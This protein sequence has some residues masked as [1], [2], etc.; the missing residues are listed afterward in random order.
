[1]GGTA[2]NRD[3]LIVGLA[4]PFAEANTKDPH[5][6]YAP[7]FRRF[8]DSYDLFP[9]RRIHQRHRGHALAGEWIGWWRTFAIVGSHGPMPAGLLALG[10][11]G[12]APAGRGLFAD[13]SED[14][15]VWGLSAAVADHGTDCDLDEVSVVKRTPG[16]GPAF[17]NARVLE[18]GAGAVEV[19]ERLTRKPLPPTREPEMH[20][21]AGP[22][23][24][25]GG[26]IYRDEWQE[27]VF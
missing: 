20:P 1:L 9:P 18:V 11:F 14:P 2:V 23:V 17:G 5:V 16:D 22:P 25:V 13:I 4:L 7:Q 3:R 26:R 15:T 19:W 6:F 27:P 10:E 12:E 21:V 8:V 24:L